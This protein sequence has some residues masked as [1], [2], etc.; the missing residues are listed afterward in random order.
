ML[1]RMHDKLNTQSKLNAEKYNPFINTLYHTIMLYQI[2]FKFILDY[3]YNIS[4]SLNCSYKQTFSY[5]GRTFSYTGRTFS[6]I[7]RTFS[8]I[9]FSTAGPLNWADPILCDIG[10][11]LSETNY[12]G[13]VN[14]LYAAD[15]NW[16][17]N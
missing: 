2:L 13:T 1:T 4:L 16:D 7:T 12:C 5:T 9:I 14:V 8:Y 6:Y 11:V 10:E 17:S 3:K 15:T